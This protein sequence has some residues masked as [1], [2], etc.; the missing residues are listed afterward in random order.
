MPDGERILAL[1]VLAIA[2]NPCAGH[3]IKKGLVDGVISEGHLINTVL[4]RYYEARYPCKNS[5]GEYEGS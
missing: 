1:L 4:G 3:L 2:E 5:F